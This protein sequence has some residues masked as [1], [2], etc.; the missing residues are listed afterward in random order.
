ME[1][2]PKKNKKWRPLNMN[3]RTVKSVSLCTTLGTVLGAALGA[4]LMQSPL[5][6]QAQSDAY[7][8]AP[9]HIVVSSAAG[10]PSDM[11][12]RAIAPAMQARLG[13]TLIIENV[14]GATGNI[15]MQ[16][17]ASSP[18]DGYNLAM[19][20][21]QATANEVTRPGSSF[22]IFKGLKPI[23]KIC[24]AAFT[25]AVSP[26]LGITTAEEL[27]KYGKANPG[28]LTFA[29]IGLGSGNH[30]VG[31]M[32]AAAT[33]IK[34]QHI[35][36]RGEAPA[37]ME[38]KAGRVQMMFMAGAK[39]F[40]DSNMVVALATTNK[41]AWPPMPTLPPIG[42]SVVPGFSYNGWNGLMAPPGTPDAVVQ[43]ISRA[44]VETLK[45]P[46]VRALILSMGNV[47]GTGTPEELAEQLRTDQ[48]MFKQI[49][50]ERHL[51]FED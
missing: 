45:D 37:A 36:F 44:L 19:T 17:V 39:P 11:C 38:I 25:L 5:A 15:G 41:E 47:P 18:A 29:S 7:P 34:M 20:S 32:F 31:E 26:A 8:N 23:G 28:K 22:D 51:K 6:A 1:Q 43:K 21:S 33:G 27:V 50:D 10:G 13:Q 49:I 30:L 40:M 48:T 35:P 12:M 42:K 24:T 9:I 46:K 2:P 3:I 4:I 16:R 14:T